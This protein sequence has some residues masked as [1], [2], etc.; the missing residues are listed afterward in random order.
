MTKSRS[1]GLGRVVTGL[2][3]T[4]ALSGCVTKSGVPLSG[5]LAPDIAYAYIPL[6]QPSALFPES[7]A[8]AVALGGGV[9]VTVAHAVQMAPASAL[10]GVAPDYDLAFFHTD[11]DKA[12]LSEGEPRLGA[13]VVSYAHYEDTLYHAEGVVTALAARVKAR[14]ETCAEQTAF[15]FEGNAGPGYSGGPVID[16]ESGKLVGILFGYID[17][18]DGKRMLYAYSMSRVR[19]ELGKVKPSP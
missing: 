6:K 14:C 16:A 5:A 17:Q 10:I 11:R 9:A 15:A 8:G 7:D 19:E 4:L 2:V 3:L 1:K 18:P 13:K 12:A